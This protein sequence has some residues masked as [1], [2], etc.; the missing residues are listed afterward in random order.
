MTTIE[1]QALHSFTEDPDRILRQI[2]ESGSPLLLTGGAEGDVV[3]M[4]AE[5]YRR[6]VETTDR[7]EATAA[8]K[9]GFNDAMTGRTRPMREALA[10]LAQKHQIPVDN[11][12]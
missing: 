7:L 11:K 8:V 4:P 12:D 3:V 6:L 10:D 2:H 1:R 5:E 9:Q